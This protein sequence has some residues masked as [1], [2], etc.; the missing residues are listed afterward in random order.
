MGDLSRFD[1]IASDVCP[2]EDLLALAKEKQI[3]LFT[4]RAPQGAAWLR[5]PATEPAVQ[6]H[7]HEV[8]HPAKETA[9]IDRF[10]DDQRALLD[11]FII[12]LK[13]DGP[14]H[15]PFA[16]RRRQLRIRQV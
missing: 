10:H 13:V 8:H 5:E 7:Q 11:G 9:F 6:F 1:V 16:Q 4:D 2:D 14:D 15:L 12:E 3:S